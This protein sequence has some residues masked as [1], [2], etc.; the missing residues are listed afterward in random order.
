MHLVKT[1]IEMTYKFMFGGKPPFYQKYQKWNQKISKRPYSTEPKDRQSTI[2]IKNKAK[3]QE[4]Y[5][6]Y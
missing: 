2:S 5:P 3:K 6:K 1:M 4:Q